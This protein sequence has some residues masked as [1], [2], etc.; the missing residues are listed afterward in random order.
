MINQRGCERRQTVIRDTSSVVTITNYVSSLFFQFIKDLF[1]KI[2]QYFQDNRL[3]KFSNLQRFNENYFSL[4]S[5]NETNYFLFQKKKSVRQMNSKFKRKNEISFRAPRLRLIL[6][7][8]KIIPKIFKNQVKQIRLNNAEFERE[9]ITVD[10]NQFEMI[11]SIF[12]SHSNRFVFSSSF[13]FYPPSS[14]FEGKGRKRKSPSTGSSARSKDAE[15]AGK[16]GKLSS[17]KKNTHL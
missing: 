1:K 5:K 6:K 12:E 9:G 17:C 11:S 2:F 4:D 16:A 10:S 15:K 8:P 14:R 7:I 3:I 13:F